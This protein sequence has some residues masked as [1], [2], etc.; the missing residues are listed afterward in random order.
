MPVLYVVDAS[1]RLVRLVT[2]GEVSFGEWRDALLNIFTHPAYRPGFNF[3]S[4]RR[5][6]E[7]PSRVFAER[8]A[9]FAHNHAGEFGNCRWAV[10]TA[11]LA[12]D[13]VA[14]MIKCRSGLPQVE[15]GY[16]FDPKEAREWLLGGG[17][18]FGADSA[19]RRQNLL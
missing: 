4:D 11:D 14:R 6:G 10:V 18:R 19:P 12:T 9:A 3:I 16:F 8:A 7:V 5:R 17:P 13:D 2:V 15:A 1:E